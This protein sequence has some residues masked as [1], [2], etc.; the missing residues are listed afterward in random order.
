MC[1]K[2]VVRLFTRSRRY[3]CRCAP[4]HALLTKVLGSVDSVGV[5]R[6]MRRACGEQQGLLKPEGWL[7]RLALFYL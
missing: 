7:P 3:G 1:C 2:V 5:G 4:H 6:W